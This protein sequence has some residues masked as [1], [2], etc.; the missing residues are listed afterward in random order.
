MR[1]FVSR[2]FLITTLA[3]FAALLPGCSGQDPGQPAIGSISVKPKDADAGI[4][5]PKKGALSAPKQQ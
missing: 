1:Y 3:S 2:L 5:V 4:P